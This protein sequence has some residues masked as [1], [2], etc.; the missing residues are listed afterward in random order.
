METQ[1]DNGDCLY[2]L[3]VF[4]HCVSYA[5]SVCFFT[6]YEHATSI[7]TRLQEKIDA[8]MKAQEEKWKDHYCWVN[9]KYVRNYTGNP[10]AVVL[11]VP[12]SEL[13]QVTDE[14]KDIV[15]NTQNPRPLKEL[16]SS[17]RG[18]WFDFLKSEKKDFDE[19]I[20]A[21]CEADNSHNVATKVE[22]KGTQTRFPALYA[23]TDYIMDNDYLNSKLIGVFTDPELAQD[24][25]AK[26]GASYGLD[27][28]F[29]TWNDKHFVEL[30]GFANEKQIDPEEISYYRMRISV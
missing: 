10:T 27:V 16:P 21:L 18:C 23:V 29:G 19:K 26:V 14:Y 17:G 28:V 5:D 13:D 20:S 25:Q 2:L 30:V 15:E 6:D 8:Y 1:T 7:K 11:K 24:A 4:S 9:P 3:A 12:Y 22:T